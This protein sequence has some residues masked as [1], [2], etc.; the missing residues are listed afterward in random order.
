MC[1]KLKY[2]Q[3]CSAAIN[4]LLINN[5]EFTGECEC[6]GK[7]GT[8]GQKADKLGT[9]VGDAL[10]HRLPQTKQLKLDFFNVMAPLGLIASL[11]A[12]ALVK[13]VELLVP[14]VPFPF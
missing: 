12:L 13:K 11:V 8:D 14:T 4:F 6:S 10:A 2:L 9:G 7:V 1:L 5:P 3:T